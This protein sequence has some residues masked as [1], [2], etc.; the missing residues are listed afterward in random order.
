LLLAGDPGTGGPETEIGVTVREHKNIGVVLPVGP[1]DAEAAL[2]TL[3]S[4]LYYLDDSRI[5][6]VVDDTGKH[7]EFAA[8]VRELSPEIVVLPAPQRAPGGFGGLWVKIASGYQWLLERY[9]LDMILRLDADALI[10]G[11][12]LEECANRKFAENPEAGL[13]GSYRTDPNGRPR[14]WS[15]PARRLHIETGIRGLRHPRRWRRLQ[16]FTALAGQHGYIHG[17]HVLGGGYIH[18]FNAAYDIYVKGWFRQ[19]CLATSKLGEDHIMGLL[20]VAAGYRI[21]DFA[22]PEDPMAVKWQGLPS[23]PDELLAN[24]KLVTHS[25]RSWGTLGEAEIRTIFR[26]A[27]T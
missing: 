2:D 19:P 26:A 24:K 8:R 9:H 22:R 25:V 11:A 3:A 6:L 13:L 20:A 10:I 23:H 17:E 21:A 18:S 1:K 4:A 16:L 7:A 27:R 5:I 14:D 15:W 12:G